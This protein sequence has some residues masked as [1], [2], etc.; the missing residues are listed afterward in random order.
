MGAKIGLTDGM[1][2]RWGSTNRPLWPGSEGDLGVRMGGWPGAGVAGPR[3]SILGQFWTLPP[4]VWPTLGMHFRA[5]LAGW[6]PKRAKMEDLEAKMH[7]LEARMDDFEVK[8]Y[9]LEARMHDFEI[10]MHDLEAK[11]MIW[12]PRCKIW[13]PKCMISRPK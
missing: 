1:A 6:R 11:I 8:M 9:D 4:T 5:G 13:R 12:R 3:A 2:H 7:D 10:K